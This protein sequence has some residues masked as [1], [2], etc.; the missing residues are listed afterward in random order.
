L[1]LPGHI[2]RAKVGGSSRPGLNVLTATLGLAKGSQMISPEYDVTPMDE[3]R[4]VL[5]IVY[6][7]YRAGSTWPIFG[8]LERRLARS[9]QVPNLGQAVRGLPDDLLQPLWSGGARPDDGAEMRLTAQGMALCEGAQ[10]DLE[11]FLR[12]LRWMAKRELAF[13]PDDSSPDSTSCVITSRQLTRAFRLPSSRRADVERL[14]RLLKVEHWGQ[15]QSSPGWQF[16]LGSDVRRFGKVRSIDEYVAAKQAWKDEALPHVY[17]IM[18]S[19][20]VLQDVAMPERPHSYIGESVIE[21][22]RAATSAQG[23]RGDKL[24][25]LLA[26]L[27]DNFSRQNP[28]ACHALLRAIVDHV[29]PLLGYKDF[30]RVANN[31][32]WSQTD[33]K[34]VKKLLDFKIQADDAL[35]RQISGKNHQLTMT[36]LPPS[37][38]LRRVLVE[39][40]TAVAAPSASS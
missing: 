22:I 34:F 28:Y 23:L 6:D 15:R 40:V 39:C 32:A 35:H 27:N 26:E 1:D 19:S 13:E 25:D 11:L 2:S 12:T 7:E 16:T 31:R 33:R 8:T 5:Q 37:L 20:T 24:V 21:E 9:K 14:G 38:W 4:R 10:D 17:P 18:E 36:D 29:P 3:Q 30:E